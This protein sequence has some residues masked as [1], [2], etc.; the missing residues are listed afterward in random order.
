MTFTEVCNA[1]V[2]EQ[3]NK[4]KTILE[5]GSGGSTILAAK[6]GKTIISTESSSVWLLELVSSAIE[7][8]LP[9]KIIPLWVD[10]GP[11]GE[12]GKPKDE[13]KWKNWL[14]Y[15]RE[16]WRYCQ[17]N[18]IVPDLVLIDGR[19]RLACFLATCASVQKE[20]LVLFD[21]YEDRPHY[22]AAEKLF[23]KIDVIDKRM[24]VFKVKP[25]M[26][27]SQDLL[28]HLHYFNDLN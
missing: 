14:N 15:P 7:Q 26:L 25:N 23:D 20:T 21:D 3:Y 2:S 17:K 5:Y 10:V 8:E 1:F 12:W 13:S 16:P 27:S 19:F 28:N 24:A 11:T 22:H 9:G 18:N 6:L 4:A